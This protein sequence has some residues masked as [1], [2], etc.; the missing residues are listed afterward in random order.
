MRERW[1][2]RLQQLRGRRLS[3]VI[4]RGATV[5]VQRVLARVP[6]NAWAAVARASIRTTQRS[7]TLTGSIQSRR[8]KRWVEALTDARLEGD[9]CRAIARRRRRV[10]AGDIP[11]F[12]DVPSY[13][14]RAAACEQSMRSQSQDL[15]TVWEANRLH[16]LVD[17][18]LDDALRDES[19]AVPI[20]E[21]LAAW[22]K[23]H[24]V[25][26]GPGWTCAMEAA[27][28]LANIVT[29]LEV[30]GAAPRDEDPFSADQCIAEHAWYILLNYEWSD[31]HGNHALADTVGML[32]AATWFAGSWFG[33]LLAFFGRKL[34]LYEARHQLRDDG[35]PREGSTSYHVLIAELVLH[36]VQLLEDLERPA[37]PE[38][39]LRLAAVVR[40]LNA[41]RSPQDGVLRMGD[42]DDGRLLRLAR[43]AEADMA[44]I[45]DAAA[46]VAGHG[47][48]D[49]TWQSTVGERSLRLSGARRGGPPPASSPDARQ[50]M[51]TVVV[52][53]GFVAARME[54][55]LVMT[56]AGGT[57]LHGRGHAHADLLSVVVEL[58]G[59]PF[60][61]DPGNSVYGAPAPTRRSDIS[62]A[63]HNGPCI[64]RGYETLVGKIASV[65]DVAGQI[66]VLISGPDA[67]EFVASHD[68]YDRMGLAV[69]RCVH[70]DRQQLTLRD[71]VDAVDALPHQLGLLFCLAPDL[72]ATL[73]SHTVH[74][75]RRTRRIGSIAF[76]LPTGLTVTTVRRTVHP[77]Y[78]V[79]CQSDAIQLL[80]RIGQGE[81][82]IETVI[83]PS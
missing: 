78:G 61:I 58:D 23:Q 3:G 68:G 71:Q 5:G 65:R 62:S 11:L 83:T 26:R 19:A 42:S 59:T 30:A 15:R 29:A 47:A 63:A 50:N 73:D 14:N 74:V 2:G 4:A 36:A 12:G 41:I 17:I 40:V 1:Q 46:A 70:I 6:S 60:L 52:A 77:R 48:I 32:Y 51:P 55:F 79:S 66:S 80:G 67:I 8:H 54:P 43:D 24:P 22:A 49:A 76:C 13:L 64:D 53:D 72:R 38:L 35:A 31:L 21:V 44:A 9:L 39:R 7:R 28:R 27:I 34:F 16:W 18:A 33:T 37:P 81:L 20:D 56:R 75:M 82:S 57:T 25:N 45:I 10:D 69:R